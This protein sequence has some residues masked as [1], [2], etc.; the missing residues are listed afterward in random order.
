[1]KKSRAIVWGYFQKNLGD[2][3]MLKSFLTESEDIYKKVYINSYTEFKTYYSKFG[4]RVI[5]L[6]SLIYRVINKFLH[7]FT[8]LD[9]Y[10]FLTKA[11]DFIILGGSLFMEY[12]EK[13]SDKQFSNLYYAVNNCH[14]AYAVGCNFGPYYTND[15]FAK[16]ALLFQKCEY[17]CFRDRC[18]YNLFSQFSNVH[19]APDIVFSGKWDCTI[20][21]SERYNIIISVID[22]KN[23][24]GL[25]EKADEYEDV[26]ANIAIKHAKRG[27][28]VALVA[29]CEFEGDLDAC[30]RVKNKCKN[31]SNIEI[32]RYDDL[33]IC[34]KLSRA[35][36]IY[37][38]R[39]HSIILALY[40]G[41]ICVPFLYS[42]KSLNA[43][44]SYCKS[45][46]AFDIMNLS[47][48]DFSEIVE[49][50]ISNELVD[51]I[52]AKSDR[53]FAFLNRKNN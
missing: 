35:D 5:A 2:D 43:L 17:V 27:D 42:E 28:S 29:F 49:T 20:D 24:I 19:Y 18:S 33:S 34:G 51:N 9:L 30:I 26:I 15:F 14:A 16:Y 52:I 4:V 44:N 6:D 46:K 39:F 50:D 23:R 8:K 36:K 11:S 3:L 31:F 45:F 53:H 37:A 32:L 21:T 38:T 22:L 47:E 48:Y 25:S 13:K 10:Y 41:I 40:Y 12:S 1:M 7:I